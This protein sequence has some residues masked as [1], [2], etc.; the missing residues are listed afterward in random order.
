MNNESQTNNRKRTNETFTV[1]TELEQICLGY[2]K[3]LKTNRN[4]SKNSESC[5]TEF[6]KRLTKKRSL[7]SPLPWNPARNEVSSPFHKTTN[8]RRHKRFRINSS[9]WQFWAE[10][11]TG[12]SHPYRTRHEA[13]KFTKAPA[14]LRHRGREMLH[15]SLLEQAT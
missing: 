12:P 5:F 13:K 10:P 1:W 15:S 8:L 6:R 4:V 14:H 3:C 11:R 7:P 9:H 2:N